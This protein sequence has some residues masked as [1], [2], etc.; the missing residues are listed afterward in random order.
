MVRSALLLARV[1]PVATLAV[2]LALAACASDPPAPAP[3]QPLPPV[4]SVPPPPT[5]GTVAPATPAS[6]VRQPTRPVEPAVPMPTVAIYFD[7][8]SSA[9]DS[10]AR[11]ALASHAEYLRRNRAS[12]AVIEGHTD[13]RGGREYNL[14]LGH[15]RAE[16]VLRALGLLG[17]EAQRLEAISFGEEKPADPAA[18]ETGWAK[19]RRA[20]VR[21]R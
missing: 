4:T 2:T 12:T 6:P 19:N 14:A 20:E 18:T 11:Q 1:G 7:Y 8:D 9:L 13:E 10:R 15:R 21:Y 3:A 5:G 16:A 17:I